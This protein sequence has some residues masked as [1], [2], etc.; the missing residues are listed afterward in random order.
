VDLKESVSAVAWTTSHAHPRSHRSAHH[1]RALKSHLLQIPNSHIF[2]AAA[3]MSS[4]YPLNR[5]QTS[6]ALCFK[7]FASWFRIPIPNRSSSLGKISKAFFLFQVKRMNFQIQMEWSIALYN[8]KTNS[9]GSSPRQKNDMQHNNTLLQNCCRFF[10]RQ[11]WDA[12]WRWLCW[13]S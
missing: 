10:C 12:N 1:C 5:N 6:L 11:R 9:V 2:Q 7:P 3:L 13:A 8:N 4:H